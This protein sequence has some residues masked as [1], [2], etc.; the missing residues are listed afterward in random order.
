[1]FWTIIAAASTVTWGYCPGAIIDYDHYR[2]KYHD[3][4][5][6]IQVQLEARSALEKCHKAGIRVPYTVSE[7][8]R[9]GHDTQDIRDVE[10]LRNMAP[11]HLGEDDIPVRP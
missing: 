7:Y 9:Q 1:M 5:I 2:R 3:D 4:Y 10:G 6:P 8:N 11:L